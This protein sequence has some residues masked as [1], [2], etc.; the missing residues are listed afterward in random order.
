MSHTQSITGG[1]SLLCCYGRIAIPVSQNQFV[2]EHHFVT[3]LH[4]VVGQVKIS[5]I[6]GRFNNLFLK[7]V[8]DVTAE[9]ILSFHFAIFDTLDNPVIAEL[10]GQTNVAVNLYDLCFLLRLQSCGQAGRL[11][12]DGRKNVFYVCDIAGVL[13]AVEVSWVSG[14]WHFDAA[15]IGYPNYLPAN[16]RIVAKQLV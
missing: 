12:N 10:G 4:P 14:G 6:T 9:A 1:F 7:K 16:T 3:N 13:R 11:L 15:A 5:S 8:E 2:A